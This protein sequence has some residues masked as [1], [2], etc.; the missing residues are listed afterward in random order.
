MKVLL[1][2]LLC[3]VQYIVTHKFEAVFKISENSQFKYCNRYILL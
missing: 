1:A 3:N 2:H